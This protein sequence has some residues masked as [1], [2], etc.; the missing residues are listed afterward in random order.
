MLHTFVPPLLRPYRVVIRNLHHSTLITDISEALGDLGFCVRRIENVLKNGLL[1]PLFFVDL[2]PNDNNHEIFKLSSILNTIIKVEKP[3]KTKNGPPQC[4]TCQNYGHTKNDC[5]YF[6]RCIKCGENHDFED[7]TKNKN[8]PSKCALYQGSH[9]TNFKGC[10]VFKSLSKRPK[11][12]RKIPII[13][14]ATTVPGS[15]SKLRTK[16]KSYAE[17]VNSDI[18]PAETISSILSN[19]INNLNSLISPLISLLMEVV[20]KWFSP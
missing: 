4:H 12:N 11:V 7:C 20:L 5:D 16:P 19:F 14:P 17:A 8:S 6:S 3:N 2:T 15:F 13:A 10:L 1:L 18:S 9:T